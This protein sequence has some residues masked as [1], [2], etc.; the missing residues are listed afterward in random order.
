VL[1]LQRHAGNAATARLIDRVSARSSAAMQLVQRCGPI[2]CNCSSEERAANEAALERETIQ[3][4]TASEASAPLVQ[5]IPA[6]RPSPPWATKGSDQSANACIPLSQTRAVAQW[7][8][9]SEAF[10]AEA[11]SRCAGCG[12]VRPVWDRYFEATSGSFNFNNPGQDVTRSLRNDDDTH[13]PVEDPILERIQNNVP[14][15]AP[16]LAGRTS[17]DMPLDDAAGSVNH[18]PDLEFNINTRAG[19]QLFGGVGSSEFGPDTRKMDGT[20]H[21]ERRPSGGGI[22]VSGTVT[23]RWD[24]TDGVDFCPGNTGERGA[25]VLHDTLVAVSQLEASGMAR[26]VFVEAHYERTRHLVPKLTFNP[27]QPVPPPGPVRPRRVVAPSA[28][29]F[30][31]GSD[32]LKSSA[33]TALLKALGDAPAHADLTQPF[34]VRGHTDSKGTPEFNKGLSARRAA[35]VQQLLEQRFPN[36]RGHIQPEGLGATEPVAPN[37]IDGRDNPDGRRLNRRVEINFTEVLDTGG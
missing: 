6:F 14:T 22:E 2:P 10:P 35:A 7:L 9:L 21:L 11:E 31:F 1:W 18:S 37:S 15:L 16:R 29:L 28:V 3:R 19:G 12:G 13:I 26:D 20:V 5:R 4:Q 25:A 24:L 36:L 17:A 27:D 33:S 30:D 32:Q 34:V 8:A 23:F